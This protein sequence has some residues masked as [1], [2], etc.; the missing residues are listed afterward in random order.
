MPEPAGTPFRQSH[1]RNKKFLYDLEQSARSSLEKLP[2]TPKYLIDPQPIAFQML[3]SEVRLITFKPY[4]C[5]SS[6]WKMRYLP[7]TSFVSV[8]RVSRKLYGE[9]LDVYYHLIEA[10]LPSSIF[11]IF[12]KLKTA[13]I[14]SL[15]NLVSI[16]PAF[17][18]PGWSIS[19]YK[20]RQEIEMFQGVNS[21]TIQNADSMMH[22]I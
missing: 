18:W 16:F 8:L 22:V 3:T 19:R 12:D 14:K 20:S 21:R 5:P 13:Y 15:R 1:N 4:F 10:T 11:K 7:G 17:Y 9:R 6:P 2:N